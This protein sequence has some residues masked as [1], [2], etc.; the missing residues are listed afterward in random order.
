MDV[1]ELADFAALKKLAAALWHQDGTFHG[2]AIMVGA[3]FSRS[4][5]TSGDSTKKMPLWFELAAQLSEDLGFQSADALRLAEEYQ[6][7]FGLQSM[8]DLLKTAINDQAF[9]PGVLHDDLLRLPWSEVLTTNWDTLLERAAAAMPARIYGVVRKQED[10]ASVRSP[11]IVKLHGTIVLD[12]HLVFTQEDYRKYPANY[13]AFVNF[14]RQVFIENELCLLGFSGDDP[15]FLAWVGWVRDH[16]ASHARRIYLVGALG[17]NAAKRKYLESINIAPIDLGALVADYD[18]SELAHREATKLFLKALV[19]LKPNDA[20]EWTPSFLNSDFKQNSEI[21]AF[22][23]E[24]NYKWFED[25]LSQ[26]QADRT[27]YPGWLVLPPR[28]QDIGIEQSVFAFSVS[29]LR[30]LPEDLRARLIYERA[31]R[32]HR[33]YDP[34]GTEFS[35]LLLE[36]LLDE[37]CK[38]SKRESLECAVLL[39]KNQRWADQPFALLDGIEDYIS[40]NAKYWTEANNELAYH[41]AIR[42]RDS[43]D[44]EA[45]R[46]EC[47]N[48]SVEDPSWKVRKAS[49]LSELGAID[50]ARLLVGQ[51]YRELVVLHNQN[52]R[53]LFILSRLG[54]AHWL[55]HV[56]G[57]AED[58]TP[59]PSVYRDHRCDPW[60]IIEG[61]KANID[62]ALER[63]RKDNIIEPNF[64]PGSYHDGSNTVSFTSSL[65][66]LVVM[67]GI[68]ELVGIPLR[69]DQSALLTSHAEKL[70][71]LE[72][73]EGPYSF[74]LAVRAAH[75]DTSEIIKK[76]FSRLKVACFDY[77]QVEL[78]ADQCLRA[79]S[80][81]K[82]QATGRSS[83]AGRHAL[84]RLR[85][86]IEVLARISVRLPPEK[87][88]HLFI[89]ATDLSKTPALRDLWLKD[90][91]DNLLNYTLESVQ[92]EDQAG[93]LQSALEVPLPNEIGLNY[94]GWPNPVIEVPGTRHGNSAIDRRI[95]EIIE[96][97]SKDRKNAGPALVRLIPL[98]EAGFL[99]LSERESLLS[100]LWGDDSSNPTKQATGR[101]FAHALLKLPSHDSEKL[102]I[103]LRVKLFEAS[104]DE[105]FAPELL[106]DLINSVQSPAAELKPN[107]AQ[108][109][110]YFDLLT[111][112]RPKT[113]S[114]LEIAFSQGS[115]RRRSWLIGK[116]LG[117]AIVPYLDSQLNAAM[118]GQLASFYQEVRA[119]GALMGFIYFGDVDVFATQIEKILRLALQHKD[120]HFVAFA[121]F[122][123]REWRA[124]NDNAS[125]RRLV[126]QLVMIFGALRLDGLPAIIESLQI[127]HKRGHLTAEETES[128]IDTLQVVFDS[129]RYEATISSGHEAAS[130][131]IVR[132]KCVQLAHHLVTHGSAC[133]TDLERLL[134][135]AR[136]D[137]LPEV[138]YARIEP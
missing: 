33:S 21:Q 116:A 114:Q 84:T 79:I 125:T 131:S 20:W 83:I 42:A 12:S 41:R 69:W 55:Y 78:L 92:D 14:A 10:L 109:R 106:E 127:L 68:S 44:Y 60:D 126:S 19:D 5:A 58:Y 123:I 51:A 98:L 71:E 113:E 48:I 96:S 115:E 64:S 81:W 95:A 133:C 70:G 65:H 61:L 28:L 120:A 119:P 36:T 16:L 136:R 25:R 50:E 4:A 85:V 13:A 73:V 107:P 130:V 80:Y 88:G 87:A 74:S 49:L 104:P 54:W 89:F 72:G 17:L 86:F 46:S 134:Q 26:L 7:F 93:L 75:S 105:L 101:L 110:R 108:A 40:S 138:R 22:L 82:D 97:V 103:Q 124:R 135:E 121:A 52:K 129:A 23:K 47:D 132:T 27:T 32:A 117:L 57:L 35:N 62:K 39:L 31:W 9:Q 118:Y 100:H 128:V 11:R 76:T 3:G 67:T 77:A 137:P 45:L 53:S 6:A 29:T 91:L 122:A 102:K 43:F 18:D 63:Q 24:Q 34:L 99:T 37:N 66:P 111:A 38:L 15:N 59:F 30:C 1:S 2:A 90:A 8:H 56:L 112:W 94:Q